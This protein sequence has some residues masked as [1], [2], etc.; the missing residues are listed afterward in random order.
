MSQYQFQAPPL[1]KV[2]KVIIISAAID[3]ILSS[4]GKAIGA[5]SLVNLLGLSGS[6]ILSGFI[7]QLV[8]Y[9]FVETQFMGILFNCLV[10]W[11]IGSEL[12]SQWGTKVYLRFLLITVL[13]VGIIYAGISIAFLNGTYVYSSPIHGLS[14][15]NFALLIAYAILYPDRQM[16]FMMIFPMKAL[17]FCWIL[18]GIEV[19]MAVFSNLANSW[20]HL[21]A[22]GVAYLVIKFQSKPFVRTF[23]HSTLSTKKQSKKHLYVV[24]DDDQDPPKYWQ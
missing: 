9:P 3:F 5:F 24:K 17:A 22:M 15:I 10:V 21:L 14:G 7:F 13:T 19:Y 23:L 18:V 20:A 1:T 4:I 8:T 16:S 6:G 12:E 11:F 2:N